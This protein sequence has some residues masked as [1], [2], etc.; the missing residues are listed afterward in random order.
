MPQFPLLS[1]F[2]A[3]AGDEDQVVFRG[4]DNPVT[5]PEFL[6]LQVMHTLP[7][8]AEDAVT[9][10][11]V[12]GYT[13][14]RSNQLE[15]QRL[16]TTYRP[17][18]VQR[19]W[20]VGANPRL[21]FQDDSVPF[22]PGVTPLVQQPDREHITRTSRRQ[23]MAV[24]SMPDLPNTL[25]PEGVVVETEDPDTDIEGDP[26]DETLGQES[27]AGHKVPSPRLANHNAA[28]AARNAAR[29]EASPID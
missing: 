7:D 2:V 21:P 15:Y 28:R 23:R 25:A 5:L 4:P 19:V 13:E 10:P 3:L 11:V 22:A 1:C 8:S 17:E 29:V 12:V 26:T 24:P 20:G 14:H 16:V 18:Y 6:V 27:M 9:E